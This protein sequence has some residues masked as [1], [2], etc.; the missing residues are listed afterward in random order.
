MK[1]VR[2]TYRDVIIA[3]LLEREAV[4]LEDKRIVAGILYNRIDVGMRLDV[5]ATVSYMKGDWRAP[6]TYEDLQRDSPY[7]TRKNL[8]LPPGPICNPGLVSLEAAMS[9]APSSYLY[10]LTGNNGHMYYAKTLEEHN[11][12]KEKFL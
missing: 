10:Y 9:P 12:N 1:I 6:I 5:D 11:V 8:G 2:D 4:S 3:S 7:N